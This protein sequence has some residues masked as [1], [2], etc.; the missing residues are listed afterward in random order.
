MTPSSGSPT[1]LIFLDLEG[2]W[3]G[4]S[5]S[6]FHMV[7]SLD[8][9]KWRPFVV[10]RK[11]GPAADAYRQI[12]VDYV[13]CP[14]MASFR[15]AERKNLVS[16]L[17]YLWALRRL[18]AVLETLRRLQAAGT[19]RA[20]HVNHE[21]LAV[22]GA[23]AARALALPWSCHIRTEL[24]PGFFARR[25]YG[26]VRRSA[27]RIIFITEPVRDHFEAVTGT[28]INPVKGVV[29]Y[30]I[31]SP[32]ADQSAPAA[33]QD[34]AALRVVSLSNFSPNRGLDRI[35]DIAEILHRRG[36]RT[37]RFYLFGRPAHSRIGGGASPYYQS[38][39]ERVAEARL[40]DMVLFPG[41]I[42]QPDGALRAADALIKL[43]RESNPWGRDIMEALFAGLAV[44]SLGQFNRF[45][46][47]SGGYLAKNYDPEAIADYLIRLRD[48]PALRARVA[49]RNRTHARAL[50]DKKVVAPQIDA[51]LRAVVP[52]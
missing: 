19:C 9:T 15:P 31:C 17:F 1:G 27:R 47:E 8:R 29:I 5:R 39:V 43:T 30:N 35:V 24:K 40:Q 51:V 4:S 36:V 38:I 21:S 13:V 16:F 46:N 10:L 25:V 23:L 20:L 3:G 50:F 6:L 18:P 45:V 52:R 41:H 22:T 42:A 32:P 7:E 26:L 44:V 2:G 11:E 48:E 34:D 49:E 37:I 28:R 33:M 14:E 12:K